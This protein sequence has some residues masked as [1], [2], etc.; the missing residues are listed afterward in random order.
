MAPL[1]ILSLNVQGL[2]VPQK[3]TKAF[4]TFQAK[5]AHIV[6]LQ[7][8]HFTTNTTPRFFN[9]SYPQ[10]YSASASVKKR[11]TLIAFH[12]TT[13][14][15]LKT[16]IKDPEG[17]Y[18]LL[19]GQVLD[20][21]ITIVSYY[22]PN[23]NPLPFLSHLFQI[24]NS[25]KIG[26]LL[27]CG[28]S[29]QVLLPFL[30]KTPY[31]T[32]KHQAK[33]TLP[34]LL[35]KY[36]LVDTWREHNPTKRNYTY[37]SNPHQSFSRIDHIFVTIGMVPEI[38][39]SNIIPIPW[40]DHNA[41]Y[42]TMASTIPKNH[43]PTWYLPE[44][45]LKHPAHCQLIEQALKDYLELNASP[46]ISP[47]TLWEAHKPVLRGA[48]QR[49]IGILKKERA[50]MARK[51][52]T[53]FNL[54]FLALQN[55]QTQTNRTRLD[56]A[57]LEYDLFLTD[58]ANR[59]LNRSR[60]AFYKQANKPGTYLARALN[61]LNKTFKPIKLK[62]ANRV[63]SSNPLKIVQKFSSHLKQLYSETTVFDES[64]ADSFFA[65]I[66]LP[67][68]SQSQKEQLEEPITQE[69]VALAIRE[70]KINKRP[71]P[72]GFSANYLKT[73]TELLSPRLAEAFNNLLEQKTFRPETLLATVCMIPKPHSDD[74]LCSNYR[75]ISM[76]N[77]DIKLLGKILAT[78]LN[79]FIGTLINRD[80]V[81]FMP[82]R[83]AGDNIRRAC[84]LANIAKKRGIPA[85]F[86]SLDIKQAF[87]SVS[88]AYL[89]YTLQK[90][91]FGPNFTNWIM[92]LYNNPKA[93]VKYAGYKSDTFDIRRGTRQGC[94]LSPLLFALLIEPLAQKI[95]SDP[96][97]LGIELGGHKHKL[98]LF[99]DDILL[100]LSSPQ[101][102]GPNL[103]PILDRFATF[104]GLA[105]NPK[106]CVALNIS[107]SRLELSAATVGLPFTW[108]DKSIP[109]LGTHVT[110]DTSDLFSYNYP[111][112]LKQITN[113]LKSWSQ[114]P[115][116]WLGRINAVKM[117]ILP[118]L[119]YLFRVLPS[120]IPAYFLRII[121]NRMTTFIWGTSRPRIKAK[122]LHLPKT[123]GG[124]GYPNF[125]N[126]YRAA[127]ISTLAKYHAK[128]ETPLWVAIEATEC[129]PIP[130]A[131][132][133]WIL[134]KLRGKICNPIIKHSLSLWDSYKSKYSLVSPLNPLLSFYKNP[135][136]YP[137]WI[138]PN[139]FKE[140]VRKD[141]I[142]VYKFLDSSGIMPFPT[143]CK[144]YGIP[145]S[146]L[147]RYLQIKN[148]VETHLTS[149]ALK[150]QMSPFESI[151]K[152]NPHVRGTISVLY[153]QSLSHNN[154]TKLPYVQKWESDLGIELNTS[155]W[156]QIWRNTK[157]ASSNIIALE[158][159]YKVLMRWYL[160]P[161]RIAKYAPN[162]T[163]HC[164]RGCITE[165]T[166]FHTWW[167]CPIVQ[168]FWDKIF[169]M[170]NA[171]TK[172]RILPDPKLALLNLKPINLTHTHFK[173]LTQ[174]FTA[175][176]QTIAKAWKT[177]ILS[178]TETKNRMNIAMTHAKM[179]ALETD[180]IANFEKIWNPWIQYAIPENFNKGVM[181]PW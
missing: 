114:L 146:E 157:S 119:L 57:R 170:V 120:P 118:K 81:G 76:L 88:W 166:Y 3:R 176:K 2:N 31:V 58:S 14:F 169:K 115:L 27:I 136:F 105:I 26:T 133:L 19:T 125:T 124:L 92:E 102:T 40:S 109:Y 11:G 71:G 21:E 52:E 30:D 46:E 173:L 64:K 162:C 79:N 108:S 41:V 34:N 23:L 128:K 10:V 56:K 139:T 175:A 138:F 151:C 112:L 132:L 164:Y 103:I 87:D 13:P 89:K 83:Q 167:T 84:L 142:Y 100:F 116:S 73:F 68:I 55:C 147:F 15:T 145:Q 6:C 172:L 104:S 181:M 4:R 85:C 32:P 24:I 123:Q 154:T 148:F 44:I 51:L 8:T 95:R 96:T 43:D 39:Y 177:P 77:I 107:L 113:L 63:L 42:T 65:Q 12:R 91:G 141:C 156:N 82:S 158:A 122:I 111:P 22:A 50:L 137:A 28:D 171:V 35:A 9:P 86:L 106:K 178:T 90:W 7:E 152:D 36:N 110:A 121:Q 78:R 160:V 149:S 66:N 33:W 180:T 179:E 161:S 54:A 74:T 53:E 168:K 143:V 155:D 153:L 1:N 17:R 67:Q 144:K 93:Y 38:L 99:A 163:G 49:Q 135:T 47:L 80:Q 165:G 126:Y 101:V 61:T 60:H 131:N 62:I 72:D 94:P 129:D 134:P 130:P 127:Q 159:G 97:I 29:N 37:F 5:K 70:L 140:W 25:H 69:D 45:I 20:T 174:L 48:F 16:E 150:K 75:P 18:I 98:C 59:T 117:T